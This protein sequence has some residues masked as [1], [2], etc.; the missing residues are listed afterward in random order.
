MSTW[1]ALNFQNASSPLM[2]Q[3]IF[4]HNHA[5]T[6]LILIITIVGY[7]LFKTTTNK[8]M[9]SMMLESH[10]L[11]LFWTVV[12][13]VI[14]LFIGFPSIRLL[15]L[16]DEVYKPSLTIKTIGH[17][18]YW[19]YEYSDFSSL[20]FD[21]YMVP[22]TEMADNSFRL[23]DVDN[24]TVI[25]MM[26]QVRNLITA[27]DVLHS[28]TVPS[29]GVKVDAVPGRLNQISFFTNRPGLFYGQCSEICGANHS[30]MPISIESST[31]KNFLAWVKKMA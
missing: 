27:A 10:S 7:N 3:L 17:Q 2:E 14:L 19:S 24:R 30:F 21:S 1:S 13:T 5:M 16:L 25:P 8:D 11:E 15:Y 23:I 4:F 31:T 18:W 22:L 29:L 6:I 9:D 20:E 12:P 28:W 26:T